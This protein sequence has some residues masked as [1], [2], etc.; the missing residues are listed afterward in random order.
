MKSNQG[1]VYGLYDKTTNN[2]FYIGS[3]N[4]PIIREIEHSN[5]GIKH[6]YLK[7]LVICSESNI[8]LIETYLITIAII[9]NMPIIN[10][11]NYFKNDGKVITSRQSG[12]VKYAQ[13][14]VKNIPF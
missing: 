3:T 8:R 11:S 1:M 9:R 4:N 7:P 6:F 2:L 12:K 14:L 10:I 13:H 5:N